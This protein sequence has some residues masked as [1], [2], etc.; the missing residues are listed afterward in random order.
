MSFQKE[1]MACVDKENRSEASA[2]MLVAFG[3]VKIRALGSIELEC[4]YNNTTKKLLFYIANVDADTILGFSACVGFKLIQNVCT[5]GNKEQT[6]IEKFPQVFTCLGRLPGDHHIVL[7]RNVR[8]VV[9]PA[10]RVPLSLQPALKKTLDILETQ[11][12]IA[13][14]DY[15]TEWVNSLV[16]VEKKDGT[17][18]LCLDPKELNKAIRREHY[19]MPTAE[20]VIVRFAGKKVFSVI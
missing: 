15:P 16:I 10:R 9:H 14:V 2:T 1:S 12:V 13:Q 20:D 17:L 19:K 18:R 11:G 8:P 4:R 3:G 7:D 6:L 5:M